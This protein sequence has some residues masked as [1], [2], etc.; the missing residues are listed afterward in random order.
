M[1]GQVLD[2]LVLVLAMILNPRA[3]RVAQRGEQTSH[4]GVDGETDG[5]GDGGG[6]AS[7]TVMATIPA[8]GVK[9]NK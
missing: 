1:I 7:G 9:E 6:G 2:G 3:K 8:S 5:S 4:D